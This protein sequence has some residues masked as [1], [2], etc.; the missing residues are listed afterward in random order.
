MRRCLQWITVASLTLLFTLASPLRAQN[1]GDSDA[2]AKELMQQMVTALGGDA[3][4]HRQTWEMTGRVAGFFKNEAQGYVPV[5]WF[6]QAVPGSYGLERTEQTKKRDVV[7]IWTA[8]NG[9]ELTF[10]GRKEL[11]KE[12]VEDH[13]RLQKHSIDEVIR[14]WMKDPKAIFVYE[15]TSMVGR[16]MADKVTIVNAENDNVTIELEASSHLPLRRSF[17]WRNPTYK[18]FDYDAEEYEDY[19]VYEGVQTPLSITRYRN[20]DMV[21]QRFIQTVKYN[22]ALPESYFDIN[23]PYNKRK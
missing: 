1:E 23:R 18:D 11:P 3:Y 8:D 9:Y 7:T 6:H 5:W 22:T 20:N 10:K 21:S 12:I 14:V 2:K 19:H 4:L 15:G 16:R 13:F 17:K